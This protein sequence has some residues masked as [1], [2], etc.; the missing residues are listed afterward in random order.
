MED[1]IEA[2]VEVLRLC[3]TMA[4]AREGTEANMTDQ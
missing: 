1:G 4:M 2:E 3:A